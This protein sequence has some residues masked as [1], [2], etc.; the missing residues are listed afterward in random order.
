MTKSGEHYNFMFELSNIWRRFLNILG[1]IFIFLF[2]FGKV[3]HIIDNIAFFQIELLIIAALLSSFTSLLF[4]SKEELSEKDWWIRE[5]V[6]IFIN[7]L[8][9]I[10][11]T[12]R[13]GLWSDIS[14][15]AVITILVIVVSFGNHFIEY[16]I[17]LRTALQ[18]NAR[19]KARKAADK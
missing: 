14:G 5:L 1:Y 4:L 6:C 2:L 12:K 18:I 17:D 8:L 9:F 10:F 3:L 11:I 15:F 13:A 16:C 19:V 7:E